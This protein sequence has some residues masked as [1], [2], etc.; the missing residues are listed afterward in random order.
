MRWEAPTNINEL[1]KPLQ[2]NLLA[3]KTGQA[4]VFTITATHSQIFLGHISI[5]KVE[6][7]KMGITKE[8]WLLVSK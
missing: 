4:F 2:D 6:A 1:E 7:N 8:E 3:W 5:R